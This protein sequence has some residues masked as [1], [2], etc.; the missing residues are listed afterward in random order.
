MEETTPSLELR[1]IPDVTP[2]LPFEWWPWWAWVGIFLA[3]VLLWIVIGLVRKRPLDSIALRQQAY[4]EALKSLENAK[5][6]TSAVA[7]STALSLTLRK[8][9]AV[10]FGDPS[11]FETHEEFLAR[12]NALASLPDEIRQ[13]LTAHFATLCRYKYAPSEGVVDLS[14][15][16]PQATTLLHQ[17]HAVTPSPVPAAS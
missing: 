14:L 9:L 15:L 16:V 4:Q 17:L 3:L 11:L 1:D 12:H 10:A 7:M 13:S 8:Y 5:Q 6:L 2:L